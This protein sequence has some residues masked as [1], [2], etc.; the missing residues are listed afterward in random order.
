MTRCKGKRR[1]ILAAIAASAVFSGGTV[2]AEEAAEEV[3]ISVDENKQEA[4][5]DEAIDEAHAS[6]NGP[7]TADETEAGENVAVTTDEAVVKENTAETEDES[8][9]S[10]QNVPAEGENGWVNEGEDTYYYID[11]DKVKSTIMEIDG[12]LYAFRYDGRL[13]KS[14]TGSMYIGETRVYYRAKE[15]GTLYRSEWYDDSSGSK[16]RRYYY[17]ENGYA[18]HGPQTVDGQEYLFDSNGLVLYNRAIEY[19]GKVYA[20]DGEGRPSLLKNGWNVMDG[21]WFYLKDGKLCKGKLEINGTEYFFG[22]YGV[23]LDHDQ[24]ESVYDSESSEWKYYRA[25]EGG[26]LYKNEWANVGGYWYYYGSDCAAKRGYQKIGKNYYYFYDSGYI[27]TDYVT[28]DDD[29]ECCYC[30]DENGY[31][32]KLDKEGW[33]QVGEYWYFIHD[34][35]IAQDEVLTIGK[36]LYA[37]RD[38][39]RMYD[40]EFFSMTHRDSDGA[41]REKYHAAKKGGALYT[42]SWYLISET[43]E[44]YYFDEDGFVVTGIRKIGAKD[45]AFD[46]NGRMMTGG[47]LEKDG[48][49]WLVRA[50]GTAV[51][52]PDEQWSRVDGKWYYNYGGGL[53]KGVIATIGGEKYYF[54]SKGVMA[55]NRR[56]YYDGRYIRAGA[57]GTL[58]S[59]T[60]YGYEYYDEDGKS[61]YDGVETVNG[62]DYYFYSGIAQK[63]TLCYARDKVYLTASNGVATEVTKDGIYY[64]GTSRNGVCIKN[65]K[66]VEEKGWEFIDNQYYYHRSD[67]TLLQGDA[68]SIDDKMYYFRAD[69]TLIRNG[70]FIDQDGDWR[71]ALGSGELVTGVQRLG[72]KYYYFDTTG[73]MQTGIRMIDKKY[74][75]YGDDGI[76]IGEAK[77]NSW[78]LINGKWYYVKDG[79][80]VKGLAT[81]NGTDYYFDSNGKM[82]INSISESML[83]GSN[84]KRVTGGWYY[85]NG[86]WFYVLPETGKLAMNETITIGNKS[87]AFDYY[88]SL[89]TGDW[90]RRDYNSGKYYQIRTNSSGV[91]TETEITDD[92]GV[93]DGELEYYGETNYGWVGDYYVSYGTV[94]RNEVV[95]GY[96]VGQNG[97]KDTVPGWKRVV[98]GEPY[99]Y[100]G[101]A[102]G[103]PVSWFYVKAD[104]KA[105]KNELLKIGNSWYYF[106][107]EG[108]MQTGAV[109]T[110]YKLYLLDDSGKLTKTVT[111][112]DDGWYAAGS[113]WYYLYNGQIAEDRLLQMDGKIYYINYDGSM[114]ADQLDGEYYRESYYYFGVNG[115]AELGNRGWVNKNGKMFY[116]DGSGKA[117]VGW[118]RIGTK[119]YFITPTEGRITGYYAIYD[120]VYQFGSDGALIKEIHHDNGWLYLDG[121]WFYFVN[122]TPVEYGTA[123]INGKLYMFMEKGLCSE[124]YIDLFGVYILSGGEVLVNSWKQI[125]GSWYYFD[126]EGRSV[127][128]YRYIGNKLYLFDA[129]GKMC[130]Q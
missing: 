121:Q 35:E 123:F 17:G 127:R 60:W 91:I 13:L 84:G 31:A 71:Y 34:G 109:Y 98:N 85:M 59:N 49:I 102:Y 88:G 64:V 33:N 61:F 105:A 99:M 110:D 92:W 65:G 83:F 75:L 18:F 32:V 12:Q 8:D 10:I 57:K 95:N 76:Y 100:Y 116:F 86:T 117:A 114:A 58:L 47:T 115:Q 28:Y 118:T 11:G 4:D 26:K 93:D 46:K 104:G 66:P 38:N 3:V 27:M 68:Y 29:D 112:P 1:I 97:K 122:G 55:E 25:K 107:T 79:A 113:K 70:W 51:L 19:D 63:N 5:T 77:D 111:N 62:K 53:Y 89:R 39:G 52:L 54:N 9:S 16:K 72:G 6:G 78:N 73:I 36:S 81:I 42:N 130:D 44:W 87:Y 106:D 14:T 41:W 50:D 24:S 45:Y 22:G 108:I 119:T 129:E 94:Y 7:V 40:D 23:M 82:K 103:D 30:A 43:E 96:Y 21:V 48:E 37:F 101:Y 124:G 69:G 74:Y 56:V 120:S 15:D 67:A 126:N 2:F 90:V 125:D 80:L 20:S 128:G